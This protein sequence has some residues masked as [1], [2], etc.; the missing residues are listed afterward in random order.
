[1]SVSILSFLS[2]SLLLTSL[3]CSSL[4]LYKYGSIVEISNVDK[5][6]FDKSYIGPKEVNGPYF[7][8]EAFV[9]L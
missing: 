8:Y 6:E 2:F 4:R 5:E 3:F 9:L 1:L 7:V